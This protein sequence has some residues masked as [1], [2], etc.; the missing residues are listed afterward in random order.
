MH[1]LPQELFLFFDG[2]KISFTIAFTDDMVQR[3]PQHNNCLRRG[4]GTIK[5]FGAVAYTRNSPDE[6]ITRTRLKG[7]G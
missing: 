2:I 5:P 3:R 1:V 4:A 6:G 7:G